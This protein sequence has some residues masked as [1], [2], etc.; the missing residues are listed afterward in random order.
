MVSQ[1]LF[2]FLGIPYV[3]EHTSDGDKGIITYIP[4]RSI[5]LASSSSLLLGT[6][7]AHGVVLAAYAQ[8]ATDAFQ[9]P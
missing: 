1:T 6:K 3:A 4:S 7:G 9:V 8:D 2:R 5:H